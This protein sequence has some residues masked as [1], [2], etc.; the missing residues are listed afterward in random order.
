VCLGLILWSERLSDEYYL[1]KSQ[2]AS[3]YPRKLC[4]HGL[5]SFLNGSY[6]AFDLLILAL[7]RCRLP[8]E[9]K[10]AMH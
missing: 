1:G 7:L 5:S 9:H 3:L 4:F 10:D 8:A 2:P 6:A